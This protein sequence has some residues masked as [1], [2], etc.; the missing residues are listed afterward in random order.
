MA[1]TQTM[2]LAVSQAPVASPGQ[3]VRAGAALM[4]AGLAGALAAWTGVRRG[5]PVGAFPVDDT[6]PI[7]RH[8]VVVVGSFG[9]F[10]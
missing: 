4:A 3:L 10:R 9:V 5:L 8:P 2:T 6:C 1:N 7:D